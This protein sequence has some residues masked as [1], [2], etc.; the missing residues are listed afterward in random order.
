MAAGLHP[1]A[2]QHSRDAAHIL[3]PYSQKP[4]ARTLRTPA[5]HPVPGRVHHIETPLAAGTRIWREAPRCPP[6]GRLL[7]LRNRDEYVAPARMSAIDRDP[8]MAIGGLRAALLENRAALLRFLLAR[9]VA[10]DE[11]EDILQDLFVKLESH[12]AGPV[13]EPRAYLYRM[14]EN[15]LLDRRRSAGRRTGREE[16]WATAQLGADARGGRPALGR[17]GPDRARAARA[18]GGRAGGAARAHPARLPPLSDRRRRRSG[19]SPPSSGSA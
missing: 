3:R 5:R 6:G 11:A 19:R 1:P 9:R 17:A 15:L 4:P 18:G 14:A 2:R 10:A 13:A 8:D 7:V 12:P 16:A